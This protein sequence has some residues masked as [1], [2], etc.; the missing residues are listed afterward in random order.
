MSF[1]IKLDR[2][3]IGNDGGH[4]SNVKVTMGIIDKFGVRGDATLCV[5]IFFFSLPILNLPSWQEWK[6]P[7]PSMKFG[8]LMIKTCMFI[9][10]TRLL[11]TIPGLELLRDEVG[12]TWSPAG[13]TP[14]QLVFRGTQSHRK[15][16][17]HCTTHELT[18]ILVL[19]TFHWHYIWTKSRRRTLRFLPYRDFVTI[20]SLCVS[21]TNLVN[22]NDG[23]S[24]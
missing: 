24:R 21:Q 19:L 17:N 16:G 8:H 11:F 4:S 1:L 5:V 12:G 7:P 13:I 10:E 20:G 18:Y 15:R 3:L 6:I 2:H 23:R 14:T 22:N 9:S